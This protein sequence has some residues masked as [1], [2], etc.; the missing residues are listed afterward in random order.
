VAQGTV[1]WFNAQEGLGLIR[2]NDGGD[3]VFVH[4]SAVERAGASQLN[5]G[6]TVIFDTVVS[7]EDGKLAAENL[8][9]L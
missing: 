3:D 2:P 6:Q 7:P 8:M 5:E 1:K 4:A 9:A